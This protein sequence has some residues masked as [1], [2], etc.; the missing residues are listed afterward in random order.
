VGTGF[1]KRTCAK[2]NSAIARSLKRAEELQQHGTPGCLSR[3]AG[4]DHRAGHRPL[5]FVPVEIAG[6]IAISDPGALHGAKF[7]RLL[8]VERT[9]KLLVVLVEEIVPDRRL[10]AIAIGRGGIGS[11]GRLVG[12][13]RGDQIEQALL[14]DLIQIVLVFCRAGADRG[15]FLLRRLGRLGGA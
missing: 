6:R 5:N 8:V 13:G 2:S 14:F 15:D 12:A 3:L 7:F 1:P 11:V 4:A 10:G 9:E